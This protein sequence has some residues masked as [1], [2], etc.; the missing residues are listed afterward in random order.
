MS[1]ADDAIYAFPVK[2]AADGV[3]L[4]ADAETW[5]IHGENKTHLVPRPF[6]WLQ[7][8]SCT[9]GYCT[10][11]PFPRRRSAPSS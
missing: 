6:S 11:V 3:T 7:G 9:L 2:A 5:R 1:S 4:K 8:R 10:G